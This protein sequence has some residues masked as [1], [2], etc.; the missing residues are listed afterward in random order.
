MNKWISV[1]YRLPDAPEKG[2]LPVIVASYSIERRIFHICYAEF[3]RNNFYDKYNE[4]MPLEDS[5]WPITHWMPL[6]EAPHE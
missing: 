3:E 1:K 4:R 5:Y 6:P 2:S